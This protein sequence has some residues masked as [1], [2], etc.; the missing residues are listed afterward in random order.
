MKLNETLLEHNV[1]TATRAAS[2]SLSPARLL[3]GGL[4][5][6]QP[7]VNKL[8]LDLYIQEKTESLCLCVGVHA[9]K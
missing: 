6:N 3:P 8:G 2:T 1:I 9:Q 7:K 5:C 4:L